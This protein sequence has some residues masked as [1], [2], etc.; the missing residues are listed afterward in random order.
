LA[1]TVNL[2]I[3]Q[4]SDYHIELI[5]QNDD[6]STIDLTGFTIHSQFRK[7][8]RSSLYYEFDCSIVGPSVLGEITLALPG[9]VS[10]DIPPGRYLYDVE[11]VD[12]LNNIQVRVIEGLVILT[13]EIT[14]VA[15]V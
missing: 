4:G 7:S 14:R 12:S 13:P 15:I 10:T 3:D 2:Y 8:F 5:I 11:I 9:S 6:G 1:S